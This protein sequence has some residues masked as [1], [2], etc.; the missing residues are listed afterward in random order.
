MDKV[1]KGNFVAASQGQYW[2]A[3]GKPYSADPQW[4]LGKDGNKFVLD[5]A[6]MEGQLRDRVPQA[7]RPMVLS[8]Q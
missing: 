7:Y 1:S 5:V 6:G 2:V 3:L 8:A 4:V